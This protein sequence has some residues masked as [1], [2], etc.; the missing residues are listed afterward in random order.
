MFRLLFCF[1]FT[2]ILLTYGYGQP[3]EYE[4]LKTIQTAPEIQLV[5]ESSQLLQSNYYYLSELIVDKL[6]T[7]QPDNPNYNYRKGFIVL[8]TKKDPEK[9]LPY[10]QIACTKTDKNFDMYSDR[11]KSA[12]VDAIYHLARCY[13]YMGNYALAKENYTKFIALSN[14]KSMLVKQSN[15]RIIQCDQAEKLVKNACDYTVVNIGPSI[16]TGDPEYSPVISPDGRSL[17]FTSRRQW[18]D[19]STDLFRDPMFNQFPE[20]IYFSSKE[21]ENNW[22]APKKLDFCEGSINEA[23]VG[24][25]LD[26]RT[27][28]AYEDKSTAEAG[29]GDL[30]ISKYLN[31]QFNGLK[32]MDQKGLNTPYW[33]THCALSMD[34]KTL[35]FVS[36]RPGGYGGRDIYKILKNNSG[37]WDSVV[38]LGPTINT[39]YDED[40]PFLGSDNQTLFFSCNGPSSM[41]EF[42]I[43]K[44]VLQTNGTWSTP[45][46]LGYPINSPWDD[47]FYTSI[48]SGKKAYFSSHRAGGKGEKD[49]YEVTFKNSPLK[50]A[51]LLQA[52]ILVADKQPIPE[53]VYIQLN[54]LDCQNLDT[55]QLMPRLSDGSVFSGLQPCKTY[56]I[57]FHYD[58]VT[59]HYYSETFKT[60]CDLA[61]QEVYKEITLYPNKKRLV[62]R[63]IYTLDGIVSDKKT[64]EPLTNVSVS[65]L[66]VNDFNV[67]T[68]SVGFFS[69]NLLSNHVYGDSIAF[70]FKLTKE[71]Y[72]T[73]TFLLKTILGDTENIHVNYELERPEIGTDL[74][75]TLALKPIY[76]DLDKYTIRPDAKIEL[77][78]IVQIMND[79]PT[80]VIELGSHTDCRSSYAYNMTLS[81]NRAKASAKYIQ[82]RIT[83]PK[84]IFG[85]GY[86]E[87]KL[88]NNCECEGSVKS[89][90]SEEEHQ[91]NRRTEFR[92]VKN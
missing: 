60:D 10:F 57:S 47:V 44:S 48:A 75:K 66:V 85:K 46:N 31:Q 64:K 49:I 5:G 86:G 83:N 61:Y 40:C 2:S 25:S 76:F 42:D 21:D 32:L 90:C 37:I 62:P 56:H 24:I 58:S 33:E 13:Q 14:P 29:A 50:Q 18:P 63:K 91:A 72:L 6:L 45:E 78:K 30:Y 41:G 54:C 4:V 89:N 7:L 67:T 20:D 9:A 38:N 82:D 55:V 53:S 36:N 59:P 1:L 19:E 70:Q 12:P 51:A 69:T 81:S 26:E 34:N 23:T 15:L 28:F 74:A 80:I 84:R 16:N 87:S 68:D 71:G 43:F 3:T 39:P 88:V 11:E 92:I 17:F 52:K 77:D 73:Q 22:L 65:E 35:Y 8:D 79:N 27:I